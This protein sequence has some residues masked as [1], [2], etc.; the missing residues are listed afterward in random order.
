MTTQAAIVAPTPTPYL[1]WLAAWHNLPIPSG[2][3]CCC[4]V[5]RAALEFELAEITRW[6]IP[7]GS[8]VSCERH[9]HHDGIAGFYLYAHLTID[10]TDPTTGHP[11]RQEVF[12]GAQDPISQEWDWKETVNL[13]KLLTD[14]RE[15]TATSIHANPYYR[16]LE[17]RRQLHQFSQV[18]YMWDPRLPPACYAHHPLLQECRRQ[19]AR[20]VILPLFLGL[21]CVLLVA[22]LLWLNASHWAIMSSIVGLVP[23][24][25]ASFWLADAYHL[26]AQIQP[27]VSG[28]FSIKEGNSN[29][30]KIRPSP[31]ARFQ[32]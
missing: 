1:F 28:K 15:F 24:T 23:F 21:L 26:P 8:I 11:R 29:R 31:P 12:L 2:E 10:T 5:T 16:A 13:I 25:L 3:P 20:A 7:L 30:F 19:S 22:L 27:L 9:V 6:S 18:A 4:R 32:W 14:L 17:R